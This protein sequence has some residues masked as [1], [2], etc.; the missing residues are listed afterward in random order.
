MEVWENEKCRENTSLPLV[1]FP[2]L[3]QVLPNF[4]ECL[5][6][7]Y[8][9]QLNFILFFLRYVIVFMC[10]DTESRGVLFDRISSQ[11]HCIIIP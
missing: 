5:Y 10:A 11:I 1:L 4:H 2:Q 6:S 8:S 9:S 7:R 3:L